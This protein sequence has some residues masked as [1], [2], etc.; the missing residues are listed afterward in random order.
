[1]AAGLA[2]LARTGQRI[3]HRAYRPLARG[4]A[5]A[6][7]PMQ[8]VAARRSHRTRKRS[9]ALRALHDGTGVTAMT[10]TAHALHSRRAYERVNDRTFD[11][12]CLSAVFVLVVHA[13]HLP[14][15]LSA[16]LAAALALRW[17]QRRERPGRVPG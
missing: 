15:W 13:N 1:M 12:M 16:A 11:L 7:P 4:S 9:G 10:G 8:L 3:A 14:W 6:R 17:W 5:S 2:P